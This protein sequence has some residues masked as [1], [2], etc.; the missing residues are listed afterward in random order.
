[1]ITEVTHVHGARYVNKP[2]N[3][4]GAVRLVHASHSQALS[5]SEG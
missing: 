4:S 1:M 5:S 2:A 3:F